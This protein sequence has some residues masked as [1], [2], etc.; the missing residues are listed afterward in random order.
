MTPTKKTGAAKP[1]ES[2]AK[3]PA[4]TAAEALPQMPEMSYEQARAELTEVVSALES[5]GT[6]LAEA[7]DLW[8]QG[9]KLANICQQW[10]DGA[11]AALSSVNEDDD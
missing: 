9:E 5:G 8:R 4:E 11:E 7:V 2:P 1:A 10:L 3:A 6:P